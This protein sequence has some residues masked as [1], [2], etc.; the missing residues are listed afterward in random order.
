[1]TFEELKISRQ[2]LNAIDDAGFSEPTP[3]QCKAIPPITAG[4]DVVGIAQTGTG[5]TAA[6]ALP[7]LIKVKYAQ[8]DAPR[9]LVL[10]P[11]KELVI[12]VH[13]VFES[14][15]TYT[16]IRCLALYGGVGPKT[17]LELI[18]KGCDIIVATPGRF[19][20]LYLRNGINPK[21][22]KTLV[23]DEADRMMDMGFMPQLRNILEIIPNKRQNLLFSATFPERVEKLSEEFLLWPTRIETTPQATPVAT[24]TQLKT[25]IPNIRTK[26]NMVS[27]LLTEVYPNDRALVFVRTKQQAEQIS[28]FL[29]RTVSGGV[30]GLHSNKAQN[31]RLYAMSLFREGAI[32]VL[33]STDVSSRGIDVPETKLVIN[34]TVPRNSADY[35]HRIGRTGRAFREGVAHTL[36]DPSEEYYLGAVEKHLPSKNIIRA[37][38][39]PEEVL[40]EDTQPAEAKQM[41][42]D[43]DLQKRKADPTFQGAFHERKNKKSLA[44]S[45]QQRSARRRK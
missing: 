7:I 20:D 12:Q 31:T 26:L 25:A 28:K 5:K 37:V 30:R 14:F 39:M 3:I 23:L 1:M 34:C 32:R 13:G 2:F 6:F 44:K 21:K 4:Q 42:M 24:V 35:V 33:V 41:A 27:H 8:G 19:M 18:D 22:I 15:A 17:Q 38:P 16:D 29:E 36:Y 10:V 45:R 40:I 11:T 9:A 43:I